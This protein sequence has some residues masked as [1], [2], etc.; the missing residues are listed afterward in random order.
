MWERYDKSRLFFLVSGLFVLV[1]LAAILLYRWIDRVSAADRLQQKELLEVAFRGFQSDF[2]SSIQEIF[3]SFRP[4]AGF[5]NETDIEA[6]LNELYSQW[7]NNS[8]NPQLIK[9][10]GIGVIDA[11]GIPRY[12][13]FLPQEK[14][15]DREEW[16]PGLQ[17]YKQALAEYWVSGGR[18]IPLPGGMGLAMSPDHPLVVLPATFFGSR[19]I[20]R[21]PDWE[22]NSSSSPSSPEPTKNPALSGQKKSSFISSPRRPPFNELPAQVRGWYFIELDSEFFKQQLFPTLAKRHFGSAGLSRYD[23]AVSA[24]KSGPLLYASNPNL[25]PSFL[26]TA[27]MTAPLLR[28]PNRS[29]FG[30]RPR[31]GGPVNPDPLQG[32]I[33]P[34]AR[35]MSSSSVRDTESTP[36][37][38]SWVL[39]ARH[40]AGSIAI[41]ANKTRYRNLAIGFGILFLMTLSIVTLTISTQ[42]A[43]ALAR[44]QMEFVAGI[45]HELR[46]P[47]SVIQSAGFNL[48][49]GVGIQPEKVH[50]YGM[51][52][53][54]EGKR[55]SEM[56]EQILNYAGIQSGRARFQPHSTEIGPLIRKLLSDFQKTLEDGGWTVEQ[57]IEEKLPPVLADEQ[58]LHGVIRNLLENAIKYGAAGKWLR[59]SVTAEVRHSEVEVMVE[60][61]GT[62]IDPVD[63]PHIFEPFYRGRKVLASSIPGAG[64]GLSLIQR[65][66]KATGGRVRVA[67]QPGGG[68]SFTLYLPIFEEPKSY[69]IS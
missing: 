65:Y 68:A 5:E 67:N 56:L 66:L 64:L 50:Q 62:G 17:N 8:R 14:K 61:R 34:D 26:N 69:K 28:T 39:A 24:G 38:N 48:A 29:G 44:Q 2:S 12:E 3:S 15:F 32:E 43:R 23:M 1:A 27:D 54:S 35:P 49:R 25:T 10:L 53:Q 20:F 19:F 55:L 45:S 40:Q 46:T 57:H 36:S 33:Q 52:I 59:V 21:R 60:D 11:A 9:N 16:P 58:A 63:L 31:G 51:V 22:R 30:F 42:K 6:H 18:P 7:L 37:G 47:L 13:R 4:Q 41:E